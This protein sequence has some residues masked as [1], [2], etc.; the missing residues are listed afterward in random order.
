MVALLRGGS[1]PWTQ[2]ASKVE[3]MGGAE[4]LLVAEGSQ[5]SLFADAG[6][7]L[8][9]VAAEIDG[10]EKDG[11][12]LLTVLDAS[13]PVNLRDVWNRPPIM[14][15]AGEL[16]DEDQRSVAVVGSRK[17]S[18]EGLRR[19]E[20]VAGV[21]VDAGYSVISGLAAGIDA[22]AH[23]K[24]LETVGRT[25]AVIGTGLRKRYPRGNAELQDEI[26]DRG[27]VLSQFWPDQPPTKST[28]PMRNAVMS[29]LAQ[30]TVVVEAGEFSGARMQARLARG[31]G[32]PVFLLDSLR[33]HQWA[34]DAADH[35]G[36]RF[37]REPAEIL[38]YLEL[39]AEPERVFA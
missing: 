38:E 12:K 34:R 23:R 18:P 27:A 8:D 28:F 10:W 37:V 22:A 24:A 13:Y 1:L 25:V 19:S 11:M 17:A 6:T 20:K 14:F 30:A 9:S 35:P 26:A 39:L 32:R 29:G 33:D 15:V 31:H 36:T 3:E 2:V 5:P 7:D 4:Q 16:R 21:M